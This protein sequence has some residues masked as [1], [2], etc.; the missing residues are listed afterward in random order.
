M[1]IAPKRFRQAERK[2]EAEQVRGTPTQRGYDSHWARISRMKRAECPVCEVCCDAVADDVDHVIPFNGVND[3]KRT[4]WR[5]LQSICR[6][7]HNRKTRQ[8]R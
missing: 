6:V 2:R 3:P 5:N 8:Q 4:E 1:P 7:C